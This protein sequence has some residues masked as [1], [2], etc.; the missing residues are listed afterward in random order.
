M[1]LDA[2]GPARVGADAVNEEKREAAKVRRRFYRRL[3]GSVLLWC[4]ACVAVVIFIGVPMQFLGSE[5]LSDVGD[6]VC[7]AGALGA[8]AGLLGLL[9]TIVIQIMRWDD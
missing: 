7:A 8:A 5:E 9:A 2:G 4:L 3:Q 6:V 1:R